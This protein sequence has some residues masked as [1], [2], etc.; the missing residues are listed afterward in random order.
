MFF[1]GL[2]VYFLSSCSKDPI[3]EVGPPKIDPPVGDTTTTYEHGVFVINEGNFMRGNASVTYI[4]NGDTVY[5]DLFKDV[6]KRGL[7]DV[8]QSMKILGNK[9]YIVVNNSN[10]IEVVSLIDFKVLATITGFNSPRYLEF[11]DSTKAYVTNIRKDISVV[12]LRTNTVTK[13]IPTPYWT[14]T[15]LRYGNYMYVTCIGSFNETS[16]NRKAH[17]YIID[18]R[19]DMIVDSILMG[20]EPVGIT[21][22]RK[23]KIWVLCTG[24]YDN[25]EAPSLKRVDPIQRLVEKSFTFPSQ[26]VVPSRLC[27]NNSKDTLYYI[28]SGVYKMPASATELPYQP[29]IPANGRLF[30]GL[31]IHPT[32]GEVY[33]SDAI[34]YVQNGKVYQCSQSGGQV[35]KSFVA[36]SIPG[37]FCFT[38]LSK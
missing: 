5:S 2:I 29:L 11:A 6:N 31:A 23:D 8:A 9:G 14:E 20:K 3:R 25:F 18:T 21:V 10:R 28:Y 27:M 26:S 34:D 35:I 24:G 13:V 12:D 30:Y 32:T 17:V 33:V 4:N 15:L 1:A 16:A 22:D 38:A 19:S 36:G 7:G 37:S